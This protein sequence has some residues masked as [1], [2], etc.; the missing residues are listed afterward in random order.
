LFASHQPTGKEKHNGKE[1]QQ[2]NQQGPE[3]RK[4]RTEISNQNHARSLYEIQARGK[5][6]RNLCSVSCTPISM[7]QN[8]S[9][10]TSAARASQLLERALGNSARGNY[11]QAERCLCKA[12]KSA[13]RRASGFVVDRPALWNDLG[14]V[15][16][17]L[18]KLDSAERYYRLALRHARQH[19]QSPERQFFL[20]NLYHNLG[21]VEHSRRRFGI[22]EK[23]A[24]KGLELRLKC[25]R[26]DSLAVAS[27][28]AALAAILDGLQRYDES[29]TYYSE[30]LRIY[31]REYGASHPEIAVVL[32]NLG[33]L[34]QATG[35][36]KLAEAYYRAALRMKQRELGAS[37]P[38][39]GVTMNNLAM[40]LRGQGRSELAESWFKRALQIL[41][42]SLG[43]SHPVTRELRNNQRGQHLC[44]PLSR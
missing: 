21:G 35:R 8:R 29:K 23:Y 6:Q 34:Y 10:A 19:P 7:R 32:N 9:H 3:F 25:T 17:Y 18:G 38:D 36:P 22:A 37:H 31:R 4:K 15:C 41:K 5:P 39:I 20:A 16:K 26:S 13:E 30:A 40:L 2:Q 42:S 28:R 14:I 12:L 27:D 24:C 33:A 1:H 43:S 44:P 11:R